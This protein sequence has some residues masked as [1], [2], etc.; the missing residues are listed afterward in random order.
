MPRNPL[1]TRAKDVCP[2]DGGRLCVK[3]TIDRTE[4]NSS[5]NINFNPLVWAAF[6]PSPET[7]LE[8]LLA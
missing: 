6:V 5:V 4:L 3:G 1:K 8:P 2:P 7:E